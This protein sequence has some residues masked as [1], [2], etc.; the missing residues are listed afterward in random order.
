V[1]TG[2]LILALLVDGAEPVPRPARAAHAK[3][4]GGSES[5]RSRGRQQAR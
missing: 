4:R 3:S 5:R 2:G 1:V